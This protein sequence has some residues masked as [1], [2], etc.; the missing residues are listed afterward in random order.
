MAYRNIMIVADLFF[1]DSA[2]HLGAVASVLVID[3][4]L[5]SPA[6]I[7]HPTESYS[8]HGGSYGS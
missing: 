4:Q 1:G 3:V 8:R 5:W 2:A 7:M 6:E